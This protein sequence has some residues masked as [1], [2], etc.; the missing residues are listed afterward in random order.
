MPL[1]FAGLERMGD[2][3]A[4]KIITAIQK[5]RVTTLDRFIYSL[6]IPLVGRSVSKQ[7]AEKFKTMQAVMDANTKDILSMDGIGTAIAENTKQFFSQPVNRNLVNGLLHLMTFDEVAAVGI[8]SDKLKGKVFVVTG[9]HSK[10]R[11]EIKELIAMHGGKCVGSLSNKVNILLAGKESG[12]K[13]L[14]FA[15]ETKVLIWA[16]GDLMDAINATV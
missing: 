3:L 16:E 10:P 7:Y 4:A 12:P 2:K 5:A 14:A 9:N 15:R 6:G 8:T 13:K 1:N 11:E